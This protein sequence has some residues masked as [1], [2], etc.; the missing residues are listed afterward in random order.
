MTCPFWQA[1]FCLFLHYYFPACTDF[2]QEK[3][4]I[5]FEKKKVPCKS[6]WEFANL[7]LSALDMLPFKN[8]CFLFCLIFSWL[9]LWMRWGKNFSWAVPNNIPL[10]RRQ[11]NPYWHGRTSKEAATSS[12]QPT[13]PAGG[14]MALKIHQEWEGLTSCIFES[15]LLFVYFLEGD[16][17][18]QIKKILIIWENYF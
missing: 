17:L 18:K 13:A 5:T 7:S 1:V 16:I 3:L 10:H 15:F 9:S 4:N 8:A 12:E 14:H 2:Q 11:G 6:A